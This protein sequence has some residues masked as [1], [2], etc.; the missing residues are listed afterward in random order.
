MGRAVTARPASLYAH[1]DPPFE[2]MARIVTTR[3]SPSHEDGFTLIELLVVILIIG[4]LAAIAIPAFVGQREKA[5]DAAAKSDVRNM[6]SEIEACFTEENQYVGC[7]ASLTVANTNLNIGSAPGQVAITA[8]SPTGYTI[9]AV[10]RASTA[11]VN[12]SFTL[13]HEL[14]A[15]DQKTCAVAGKGGC[16]TSGSW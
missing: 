1:S 12:H 13:V 6:V 14:G 15:A 9:V 10:S 7:T 16:P 5:Q 8:E 2:R 11:G 3:T 4:I